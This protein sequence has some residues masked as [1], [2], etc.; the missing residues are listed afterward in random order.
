MPLL[1]PILLL[2]H[3]GWATQFTALDHGWVL[4]R[5]TVD[6]GLPINHANA[7][8]VAPDGALWAATFDGVVV[9]RGLQ[10]EVI[11]A[12]D[13]PGLRTSRAV[14]VA[15][16]P[17]DGSIWVS[18]E[19]TSLVRFSAA[20]PEA[21]PPL[22]RG[23]PNLAVG[24]ETLW[25]ASESSL[26]RLDGAPT[27]V[28][29]SPPDVAQVL[30]GMQGE[31]WL[32]TSDQRITRLGA[33][34]D[35]WEASF[36]PIA[37]TPRRMA[38]GSVG[39]GSPQELMALSPQGPTP[40]PA[41]TPTC[42]SLAPPV[43]C[44]WAVHG[45]T[46]FHDGVEVHR[47]LTPIQ[48]LHPAGDGVWL[49]TQ[50]EGLIHV[51]AAQVT[52]HRPE[53]AEPVNTDRLWWDARDGTLW[54]RRSPGRW[55]AV[56][57]PERGL[58]PWPDH[59]KDVIPGGGIP[60]WVEGDG[61]IWTRAH[62]LVLDPGDGT[63]LEAL[64][65]APEVSQLWA[66]WQAPDR[67]HWL[68]V[69][70]DALRPL[71]Q[72]WEPARR[73]DGTGIDLVRGITGLPDGS[74]LLGAGDG[75]YRAPAS[76][77]PV[78]GPLPGLEVPVRGVGAFGGYAW[79]ATE[80]RGLCATPVAEILDRGLH[81]ASV[82]C[83]QGLRPE[84]TTIHA[85]LDDD[86]DRYWVSTNAGIGVISGEL[87]RAFAEG[88]TQELPF[89]WLDE[90]DGM[91]SREGN[92]HAG[93]GALQTPD[94]HLWF[95]T[96]DGV[97]EVDPRDIR[98]PA[99]P[100]VAITVAG[101]ALHDGLQ[102]EPGH[103]PI[104]L[105]WSAAV[106]AWDDQVEYRRR[107]GSDR[108]WSEPSRERS[109]VLSSLPAGQTVIEIQ[110]RLGGA[111]GPTA[112]LELERAPS[113]T[114][115]RLF[116]S[117]LLLLA[118]GLVAL[119]AYWRSR[120]L[121]ARARA[122]EQAVA[123]RTAE[124]SE[125]NAALAEG[126]A[127]LAR[128]IERLRRAHARSDAQAEQLGR[129]ADARRQLLAD[130]SHELRTPLALVMG[131]LEMLEAQL[132]DKPTAK[133]YLDMAARNATRLEALVTQLFELAKL[134]AGAVE[135]QALPLD[136]GAT[137][138]ALAERLEPAAV[139]KSITLTV[140]PLPA[141]QLLWLDPELVDRL[142]SNLV[143]N[144][145]RHTP[146]GGH[147]ELAIQL[148]RDPDQPVRVTV[149]DDGPGVPPELVPRV[150]ERFAQGSG[151]REA[152]GGAG[153]GLA[154]VWQIAWLH[155]GRVGLDT[156]VE[157][158]GAHFWVE[159]PR[160]AAHLAPHEIVEEH[161]DA[162]ST[163]KPAQAG[164]PEQTDLLA[165]LLRAARPKLDERGFTATSLAEAMGEDLPSL[166]GRMATLGMTTP[167]AWLL[168]QRLARGEVL[169]RGGSHSVEQVAA[170]VGLSHAYFAKAFT[171]SRGE[172]PEARLGA[173]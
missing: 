80:E 36:P 97:V 159:L 10:V 164:G 86:Q 30:E 84:H 154:M 132:A 115:R 128:A 1:L 63:P 118:A 22:G 120:A 51:R 29:G 35:G 148:P 45:R 93:A 8:A 140:H 126:N 127:A 125:A 3:A 129:Q 112:R 150:F 73:A 136:L 172:P 152:G 33:D 52:V 54:A 121:E 141:P 78:E 7:V 70:G 139:A 26:H 42:S 107:I 39:L 162:A 6:D 71:A 38:D 110:A 2:L 131:P 69:K 122:L 75:A 116:I 57:E 49:A 133:R 91:R 161:R 83:P 40:L 117:A 76:P 12:R 20:G 119:L 5:W 95:A 24:A 16:H 100:G 81:A 96:Q 37:A 173:G 169:L 130:L 106:P 65:A 149:Q 151:S 124:L 64:E 170:A 137:L 27:L 19:D 68:G 171:A 13:V 79:W 74:V 62:R 158:Q 72:G 92:G 43:P 153:L 163:G 25:A 53:A 102:L 165:Q 167:T 94:G 9:L 60:L 17:G 101:K 123:L 14:S 21:F 15:V 59:G 31:L 144:A 87:L 11:R 147:I 85:L 82:R 46:L 89:L 103:P 32:R 168:E 23:I 166:A 99:P 160:G 146:E 114:E 61:V 4:E 56:L 105:G 156:P 67:G 47:F 155:G 98:L 143:V 18:Y 28:P 135:V 145:L 55:W 44:S 113:L 50:G 90:S 66:A 34:P 48:D 111:W 88:R 104:N 108:P 58:A 134:E 109:L 77:G 138:E 157:G 142:F 41:T